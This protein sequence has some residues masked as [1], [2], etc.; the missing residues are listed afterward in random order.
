MNTSPWSVPPL[1][2][3]AIA[4][5]PIEVSLSVYPV[6]RSKAGPTCSC[7]RSCNE[8]ADSTST[9]PEDKGDAPAEPGFSAANAQIPSEAAAAV[10]N[11]RSGT[12][13][14]FCGEHCVDMPTR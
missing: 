14:D 13:L 7:S 3:L 9:G 5:E 1:M 10:V 4:S 12:A 2:P 8:P 6:A 11:H